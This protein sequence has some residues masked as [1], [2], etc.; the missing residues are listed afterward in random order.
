MVNQSAHTKRTLYFNYKNTTQEQTK[1]C[2]APIDEGTI[3]RN[4]RRL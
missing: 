3:Y 4:T 1:A 2:T